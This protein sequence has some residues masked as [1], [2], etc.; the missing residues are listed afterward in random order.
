M[1]RYDAPSASDGHGGLHP[2]AGVPQAALDAA[3]QALW[4]AGPRDNVYIHIDRDEVGLVAHAVL[5]AAIQAGL[6]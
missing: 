5:I 6:R 2:L 4:D 3:E 1:T